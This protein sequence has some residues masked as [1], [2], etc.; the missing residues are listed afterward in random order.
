MLR[1]EDSSADSPPSASP[2]EVTG[3][4]AAARTESVSPRLP[5][6]EASTQVGGFSLGRSVPPSWPYSLSLPF[7]P[8]YARGGTTTLPN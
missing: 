8:L 4:R 6:W 2:V 5:A 3:G 1:P 7:L